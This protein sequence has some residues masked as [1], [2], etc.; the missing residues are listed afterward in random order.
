MET[1]GDGQGEL[2][3]KLL[4]S[5]FI[6]PGE[7]RELAASDALP[8]QIGRYT[9]VE[10]LGQGATSQVY[11]GEHPDLGRVAIKLLAR[12][13]LPHEQRFARETRILAELSHPGIVRIRDAGLHDGQPYYVMDLLEG[14]SLEE[15]SLDVRQLATVLGQVALACDAAHERGIVHRDLK[16]ANVLLQDSG[17]ALVADFGIAR[18]VVGTPAYMAPE[19]IAGGQL[20]GQ[21]DVYA[22]GVILYEGLTGRLPYAATN[23]LELAAQ[24]AGGQAKHPSEVDPNVD[25]TLA[26]LALQ[27][28]AREPGDRP[29]MKDMAR[30]LTAWRRDGGASGRRPAAGAPAHLLPLAAGAVGVLLLG[31]G[32]LLFAGPNPEGDSV[33]GPEPAPTPAPPA[34]SPTLGT[35]P[36]TPTPTTPTPTTPTPTTPGPDRPSASSAT[37]DVLLA[38][39]RAWVAEAFRGPAAAQPERRALARGLNLDGAL[40]LPQLSEAVA[41]SAGADADLVAVEQA[42]VGALRGRAAIPADPPLPEA[43]GPQAARVHTARALI[44]YAACARRGS[45]DDLVHTEALARRSLT[46]ALRAVQVAPADAT[47]WVVL[48]RVALGWPNHFGVGLLRQIDAVTPLSA[49]LE[50][51]PAGGD[52]F[53]AELARGCLEVACAY[54]YVNRAKRVR[55][56]ARNR[57]EFRRLAKAGVERVAGRKEPEARLL[58]WVAG[59]AGKRFELPPV[60]DPDDLAGDLGW[61]AS[62]FRR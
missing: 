39:R 46:E 60:P 31:V 41:A 9:I 48:A 62:D 44:A 30:A 54:A 26:D 25:P 59:Q 53:E 33:L 37:G 47:A 19:Q 8:G 10:R 20:D 57:E 32:L 21:A 23:L 3:R 40:D 7:L 52:L 1:H 43:T 38:W 36:T 22:L 50:G 24:V 55:A 58:R 34:N 27:A 14:R 17:T 61:D 12:G 18:Q 56:R 11:L 35:P 51:L 49:A 5:S 42:L 45:K 29:S 4:G 13:T 6:A 28:M 16:P 15:A 2:A